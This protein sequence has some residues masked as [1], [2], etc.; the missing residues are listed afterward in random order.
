MINDHYIVVFWD[1]LEKEKRLRIAHNVRE[2]VDLINTN[3]VEC[4][5]NSLFYYDKYQDRF[6][7]YQLIFDGETFKVTPYYKE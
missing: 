6:I 4:H 1:D 5:Y 7:K 2:I 3:D